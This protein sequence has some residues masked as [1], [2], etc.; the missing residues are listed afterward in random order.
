[1]RCPQARRDSRGDAVVQVAPPGEIR[2]WSTQEVPQA[3]RLEYFSAALGDAV[4]PFAIDRADPLR[5][6]VQASFAHLGTLGIWHNSVSPHRSLRGPAHVARTDEHKFHLLMPVT[7]HWRVEHRRRL[8]LLPG[9]ILV[10]DTRYPLTMETHA[11]STVID[12]GMSETWLRRWFPGPSAL[13]ARHI[14]GRSPWRQAL[15]CF[16]AE[17]SPELVARAPLPLAVLSD[18]VG[19]L[20]A[21]AAGTGSGTGRER[22]NALCSLHARILDCIVQRCTEP[23]LTAMDVSGSLNVSVRTLH[24]ALAAAGETFGTR[25]IQA[26]VGVAERMLVSPLFQRKTAAEIGLR[27]GF[28][29]VTHFT[30]V[31]RRYTGRSPAQLRPSS[32]KSIRLEAGEG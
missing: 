25:L 7:G 26:R 31:I 17:L 14:S 3:Q 19:S 4:V 28:V 10:H 30:R 18:Q 11:D 29:S 15:S 16:L 6:Q 13:G 1:L 22:A 27:A 8:Q 24:R 12:V 21:L 5:F 20:L 23:Q 9:D 2:Y 32:L